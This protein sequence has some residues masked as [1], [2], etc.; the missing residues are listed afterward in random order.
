MFITKKLR[1]LCEKKRFFL[2]FQMTMIIVYTFFCNY[3]PNKRMK[4]KMCM[5]WNTSKLLLKTRTLVAFIESTPLEFT[6]LII[7]KKNKGKV[8]SNG[9]WKPQSQKNFAKKCH[10]FATGYYINWQNVIFLKIWEG[11]LVENEHK[12]GF[13]D[14]IYISWVTDQAQIRSGPDVWFLEFGYLDGP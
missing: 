9:F 4:I 10:F 1:E 8:L 11:F 14:L 13:S 6:V 3:A 5:F 12:F 2:L 7:A